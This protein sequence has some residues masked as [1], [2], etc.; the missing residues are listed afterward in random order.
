M[1][2]HNDAALGLMIGVLGTVTIW[3]CYQATCL[4]SE[5]AELRVKLEKARQASTTTYR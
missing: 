3:L 1:E 4:W 5:N 2:Q